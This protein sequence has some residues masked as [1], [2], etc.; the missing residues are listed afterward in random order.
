MKNTF[1]II[2]GDKRQSYLA[3]MLILDG[4][5]V[6]AF[7]N[8]FTEN[9]ESLDAALMGSDILL[10][11][12]P[13]SPDGIYLNS[14]TKHE[15]PLDTLFEKAKKHGIKRIFGGAIAPAVREKLALLGFE[16]SDYGKNESLLLGNALCTAEGAI[17]IAMHELPVT[18]HGSKAVVLG[19]G[20]IGRMLA[21]RM[22]SLGADV[23]A[24][25]RKPSDRALME[26][27]CIT[28]FS[29]K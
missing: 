27:D 9:T 6:R 20:R 22:K 28:A 16:T 13:L 1:A 11:P 29:R 7:G 25:A 4:F 18:V 26:T 17:E 24:V 23:S 19:Y 5:S 2:G 21:I 10:L 14:S 8:P 12:F 15:I 3:E